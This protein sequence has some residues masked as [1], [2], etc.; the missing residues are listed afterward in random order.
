VRR[1]AGPA[2]PCDH[3]QFLFDADPA[4]RRIPDDARFASGPSLDGL[5]K[6]S[7]ADPAQALGRERELA[8]S[9]PADHV[10]RLA[11]GTGTTTATAC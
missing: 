8:P 9:P 10:S 3:H 11:T 5:G 4:D 1:D 7:L 6:F 2:S